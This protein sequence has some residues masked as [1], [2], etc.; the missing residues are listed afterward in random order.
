M[1]T[2]PGT[3]ARIFGREDPQ[4][5]AELKRILHLHFNASGTSKPIVAQAVP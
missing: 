2:A 1:K 4:T 3:Q 5:I